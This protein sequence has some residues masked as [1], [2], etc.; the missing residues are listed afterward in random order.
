M[1]Y[2]GSAQREVEKICRRA[3]R[4]LTAATCNYCFIIIS[5]KQQVCS[6]PLV[7]IS[8]C[9]EKKTRAEKYELFGNY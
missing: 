8:A 3:N 7:A 2:N 6:R 4:P 1:K 9:L 5:Q